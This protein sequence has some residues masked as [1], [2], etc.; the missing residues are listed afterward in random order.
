VCVCVFVCVCLYVCV[1]VR[2]F[3]VC[4]CERACEISDL[5]HVD[6]SCHSSCHMWISHVTLMGW[7]RLVGS[8]KLQVSFAEYSLFYRARLQKRPVI[9]R[10][11][12]VV[13]TPYLDIRAGRYMHSTCYY[14][15]YY[16][17][18]P[19]SSDANTPVISRSLCFELLYK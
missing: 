7:L 1:C 12:L 9:L 15:C 2:V 8:L 13:A 11:L 4:E 14:T 5:S 16:T 3:V 10:S 19:F 17:F 6:Q 18:E